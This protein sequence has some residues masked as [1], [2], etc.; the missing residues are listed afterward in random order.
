MKY[1]AR[2]YG[3]LKTELLFT[4]IFHQ[5]DGLCAVDQ[6]SRLANAFFHDNAMNCRG[7]VVEVMDQDGPS[8]NFLRTDES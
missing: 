6:A 5:V 4:A 1:R 2:F 7:V 8:L 3:G